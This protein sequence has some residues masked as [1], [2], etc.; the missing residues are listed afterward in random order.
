MNEHFFNAREVY[1]SSFN[2]VSE[3]LFVP[4]RSH[5][6]ILDTMAAT[7]L[8]V[9]CC[10]RPKSQMSTLFSQKPNFRSF[11]L[12]CPGLCKYLRNSPCHSRP[13]PGQKRYRTSFLESGKEMD[14]SICQTGFPQL[15]N[16]KGTK[17]RDTCRP[18]LTQR[19]QSIK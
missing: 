9:K 10:Q 19:S 2:I 17:A 13:G 18:I 1:L 4:A 14:D 6:G 7:S 3:I 15:Q 12:G 16:F 11:L 8:W 5:Q